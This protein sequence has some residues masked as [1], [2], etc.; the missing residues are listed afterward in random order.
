VFVRDRGIGFDP[1]VVGS[2]RRGLAESI[3]GRME[4][5]GGTATVRSSP[6]NGTEIELT[7][8]VTSGDA[9]EPVAEPA[10]AAVRVEREDA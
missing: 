2:D 7:V 8:S 9:A 5:H 3:R 1:A 6:G 10:R 4:R